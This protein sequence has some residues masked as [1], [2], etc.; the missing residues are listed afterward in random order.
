MRKGDPDDPLLLQ[1]LPSVQE[2]IP[3]PTF[4]PD[5]VGDLQ[6]QAT[7]GILH[8]YRGR[9]LVM[10]TG[11]C[12]V[13]CRYCF[14]RHYPYTEGIAAPRRREGI[15]DYLRA[16]PSMREVILSGGDPLMLSD[17]RLAQWFEQL[18]GIEHL[19]RL[20]LHTRVPVVLPQRI[21][22][23]LLELLQQSPLKPVIVLHINH[24]NELSEPLIEALSRL[25]RT[26]TLLL[27]QSVLLKRVNDSVEVLTALSERLFDAGV[28]PYYLHLLDRVQGAA[29][30][31]L[32]E[33]SAGELYQGL[34][35]ALPGYLVPK[36]VR[37]IAGRASKTPLTG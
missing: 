11:A 21:T 37:E 9:A 3:A 26:D 13:H 12:A 28:L 17:A 32:D 14:R 20:R 22:P 1:V 36:L 25:K 6:A 34:L 15:L 19:Q 23:G 4:S 33:A 7:P 31:E 29:H 10:A 8:K 24:P 2:L 35:A 16:D 18:A 5:P 27:N 30:F